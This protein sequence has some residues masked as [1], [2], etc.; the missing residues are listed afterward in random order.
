MM[1]FRKWRLSYLQVR[2]N[3]D[4][5]LDSMRV[6]QIMGST[7]VHWTTGMNLGRM[8]W[9][10]RAQWSE[11]GGFFYYVLRFIRFKSSWGRTAPSIS[12]LNNDEITPP[13]ADGTK[14]Y[15]Q[16]IR[17]TLIWAWS[18]QCL[19]IERKTYSGGDSAHC[20]AIRLADAQEQGLSSAWNFLI[21]VVNLASWGVWSLIQRRYW[22]NSIRGMTV[23]PSL[24]RLGRTL[25]QLLTTRHSTTPQAT[26]PPN[27][28]FVCW[29][30]IPSR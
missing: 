25:S 16:R 9:R 26:W 17:Y 15:K 2:S 12:L 4:F 29:A 7:G 23:W 11:K 28:A 13:Q 18:D 1:A 21:L 3:K 6:M 10:Q 30:C 24:I 8:S 27:Q 5:I 14:D 22:C 19:G 20:R